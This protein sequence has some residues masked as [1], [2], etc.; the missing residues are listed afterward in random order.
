MQK[1]QI[2]NLHLG[3]HFVSVLFAFVLGLVFSVLSQEIG[4]EE[5]LVACLLW[6][7]L[8]IHM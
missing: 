2:A 8:V 6:H 5:V 1:K 4:W 7:I 3:C